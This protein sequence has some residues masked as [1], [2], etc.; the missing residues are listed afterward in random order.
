MAVGQVE[1]RLPGAS[2]LDA[3]QGVEDRRNAGDVGQRG[4]GRG[5]LRLGDIGDA[6]VAHDA[7]RLRRQFTQRQAQQ[8]GFAR[9]VAP[10]QAMTRGG[11]VVADTVQQDAAVGQRMADVMQ[12]EE[13]GSRLRLWQRVRLCGRAGRLGHGKLSGVDETPCAWRKR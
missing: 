1:V 10:D 2:G 3:G 12:A 7:A 11:E 8:Q 5:G 13:G 9:A 6:P 4:A